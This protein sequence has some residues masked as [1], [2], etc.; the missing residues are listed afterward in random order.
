MAR[1]DNAAVGAEPVHDDV[2]P[3]GYHCLRQDV[4]RHPIPQPV[5]PSTSSEIIKKYP[6][7]VHDDI[8]EPSNPDYRPSTN[9]DIPRR[10]TFT[11]AHDT[12]AREDDL[13]TIADLR[14]P[15]SP[16]EI[17]PHRMKH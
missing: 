14:R 7:V 9:P 2:P 4:R 5:N 11:S 1:N 8:G 3:T 10:L 6:S 12:F 17:T 16:Q 13:P 15:I